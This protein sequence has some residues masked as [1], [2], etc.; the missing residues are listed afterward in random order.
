MATNTTVTT[1]TISGNTP[2][3]I[4]DESS[5]KLNHFINSVDFILTKFDPTEL[6]MFPFI[7]KSRL[8]ENFRLGKK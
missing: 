6:Q 3:Y 4:F 1:P 5:S 2:N 7:V 8:E